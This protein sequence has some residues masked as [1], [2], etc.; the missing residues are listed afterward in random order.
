MMRVILFFVA[1]PV[2]LI[3][4]FTSQIFL[5]PSTSEVLCTASA[6]ALAM[7]KFVILPSHPSNDFF[8]QFPNCLTYSTKEE[9]VGVLYYALTHNPEPLE[10]EFAYALSWEAATERLEAAA[11]I[12]KAE[13]ERMEEALKSE[14]AGIEIALPPLV[15]SEEGRKGL[16][17]VLQY[18]R[19]RYRQFR[20][21]LSNEIRQNRILPKKV[22]ERILLEL[23]KRLDLD[24]DD[25]L[26]SPKLRMK[27]SPAELDKSLL[28]LYETLSE[29]PS[30][31]VLRVIGGGGSVGM[32]NLYMKRQASKERWNRI[33]SGAPMQDDSFPYFIEEVPTAD[34]ERTASQWVQWSLQRNIPAKKP[35]TTVAS[36]GES[37]SSA[38]HSKDGLKM[39]CE[40]FSPGRASLSPSNG[41]RTVQTWGRMTP[42]RSSNKFA[43]L[44]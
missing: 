22:K 6:E 26:E 15:E 25:I 9:F 4:S 44:I 28:E 32:Q 21:R 8:A 18:S 23:D 39:S 13:S 16:S 29:G 1:S 17:T 35:A 27:I 20:T 40:S 3:H 5:N 12:P 14:D 33:K 30:G 38:G 41:L 10:E 24:I 2:S 31:D 11:C 19:L 34:K 7:G 43:L 37:K 42:R 36:G